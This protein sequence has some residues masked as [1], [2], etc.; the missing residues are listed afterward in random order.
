MEDGA[1]ISLDPMLDTE[2]LTIDHSTNS[3]T[4][5]FDHVVVSNN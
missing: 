5:N 4:E 3:R 1:L 2:K